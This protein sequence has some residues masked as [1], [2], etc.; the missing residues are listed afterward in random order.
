MGHVA[1]VFSLCMCSHKEVSIRGNSAEFPP[2]SERHKS[3]MTHPGRR[4]GIGRVHHL[5]QKYFAGYAA[6][7]NRNPR[8][9]FPSAI[10]R[11][12]RYPRNEAGTRKT[13]WKTRRNSPFQS[14][15][16]FYYIIKV[17]NRESYKIFNG[18]VKEITRTGGDFPSNFLQG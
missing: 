8:K 2:R 9:S 15:L 11:R 14:Q 5:A 3:D 17:E 16:H 4:Y 13:A 10:E 12:G 7:P 1:K 6:T 18:E